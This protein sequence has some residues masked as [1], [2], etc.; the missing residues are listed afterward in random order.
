MFKL[1]FKWGAA[2]AVLTFLVFYYTKP[3][4]QYNSFSN[5][6]E[7]IFNDVKGNLPLFSTAEKN[8]NS[9]NYS[10]ALLNLNS[11]SQIY[12]NNTQIKLYKGICYLETNAHFEANAIFAEIEKS[13]TTFSNTAT[14]YKAL[15]YLKQNNYLA[16][17]NVLKTIPKHSNEYHKAQKLIKQL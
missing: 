8:F 2:L 13:N 5:H 1:I 11:L 16:C 6:K 7:L 10:E 14:W 15:N 3:K 12:L 9:K 4:P 17:K